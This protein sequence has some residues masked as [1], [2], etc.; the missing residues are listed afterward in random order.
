MRLIRMQQFRMYIVKKNVYI[1]LISIS[2]QYICKNE[3]CAATSAPFYSCSQ[4]A[5]LILSMWDPAML[6]TI[7][8]FME[9]YFI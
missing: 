3:K 7:N 2:K 8:F 4:V 9:M 6:I 5:A 1:N